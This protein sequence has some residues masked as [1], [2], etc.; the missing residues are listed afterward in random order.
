MAASHEVYMQPP[1]QYPIISIILL[2][3]NDARGLLSLCAASGLPKRNLIG[4]CKEMECSTSW[5]N[6]QGFFLHSH[7]NIVYHRM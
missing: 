6:P 2:G 1:M 3:A 4:L 7:P 5:S